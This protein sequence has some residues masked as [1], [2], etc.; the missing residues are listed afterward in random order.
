MSKPNWLLIGGLGVGG[1]MLL[2]GKIST[3]SVTTAITSTSPTVPGAPAVPATFNKSYYLAYQYPAMLAANPNVGNPNYTLTQAEASQYL[4]NY[5]DLQQFFQNNAPGFNGVPKS[6]VLA[7]LQ[8][9]WKV[10]GVPEQRTFLPLMPQ[11]NVPY[12]YPPVPAKPV[13]SGGFLSVL[14]DIAKIAAPVV[15]IL[16]I[17]DRRLNAQEVEVLVSGSAIIKNILP[18]YLNSDKQLVT[19]IDNKVNELL[20]QYV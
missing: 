19:L 7:S 9:H 13:S 8:Y 16:G 3:P 2:S 1:Y 11:S 10:F 17:D 6:D 5:L 18:F 14:G 12:V 4:A 15:A 20:T